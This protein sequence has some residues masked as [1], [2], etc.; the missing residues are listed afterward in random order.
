MPEILRGKGVISGIAIGKVMLVSQ[1]IDGYLAGYKAA[2]EHTEARKAADALQAIAEILQNNVKTLQERNMPE[3]AAIMEAHRMMAQDPML[4]EAKYILGV[5]EPQLG[6]KAVIL[7]GQEIEPSVIANIPTEKIQGVILGQG[8]TTC[9][10]VII[11]KARAIATVVGLGEKIAAIADGTEIL[12]DGSTG[13]IILQPTSEQQHEY[14]AKL[15]KQL[16]LKAHYAELAPLPAVTTDG[17]KVQLAA[18]IGAHKIMH[19][20]YQYEHQY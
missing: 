18:N 1:N 11:A 17:V 8:S 2:D 6:D 19:C 9:H 15:A 7:C 16:E 12:L 14:E 3:Q 20:P 10:A 5:K 13:E 4:K